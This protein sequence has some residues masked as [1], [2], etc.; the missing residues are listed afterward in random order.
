MK[1]NLDKYINQIPNDFSISDEH[2]LKAIE[3]LAE[4]I[5]S[6]YPEISLLKNIEQHLIESDAPLPLNLAIKLSISKAIVKQIKKPLCVSVTFAMYKENNRILPASEHPNGENFLMVKL[7]QLTWL[8]KDQP[9]VDWELIAVD[10]GC[11]EDSG[12]I[13]EEIL[14]K[15]H[16]KENAEVL[17][18]ADAIKNQLPIAEKLQSTNDSQK[19]GSITYGMWYAAQKRIDRDHIIIFT[20]ADLSTHLGQTGLLIQPLLSDNKQVTIGSRRE[21]NSVVIKK[22]VRNTRGKLFIYLWKRLLPELNYLV[23]TQCGFKAFKQETLIKIVDDLIESKFAIDIELLL[24]TELSNKKS[25][26]KVGI[27]WIDSEAEST[28]TDIQPYL[29][30]LKSISKMYRKYTGIN[31]ESESFSDFIDSLSTEQW[32]KLVEKIPKSIAE[33]EPLEFELFDDVKVSD[34]KILLSD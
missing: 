25:I 12:K 19:G 30:M 16:V 9:L 5:L 22:G 10:D 8:F 20:D 14:K 17:F 1:F 6:D 11:P 18:L 33:R 34:L 15:N 31:K 4:I 13:A 28:T 23:D 24:K 32:D 7:H 21:T 26:A 29:P 27:A 2:K 3:Q